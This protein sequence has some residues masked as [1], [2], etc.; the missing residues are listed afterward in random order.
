MQCC[1]PR[2]RWDQKC[3]RPEVRNRQQKTYHRKSWPDLF[4]NCSTA[5]PGSHDAGHHKTTNRESQN[6]GRGLGCVGSKT[7]GEGA[8]GHA[9]EFL[10]S[11]QCETTGPTHKQRPTRGRT[12]VRTANADTKQERQKPSRGSPTPTREG[13][14]GKRGGTGGGRGWGMACA[15]LTQSLAH[16]PSTGLPEKCGS[17]AHPP[18]GVTGRA[19][20]GAGA[21]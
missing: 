16:Q 8:G 12:A 14:E 9:S 20:E 13:R 2:C 15:M 19:G 7:V 6:S 18:T 3:Q 4:L 17:P 11:K 5:G 10:R 1:S 21:G